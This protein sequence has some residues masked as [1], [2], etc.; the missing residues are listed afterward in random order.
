MS[1]YLHNVDSS[2]TAERTAARI[3]VTEADA[4]ALKS[5]LASG[6]AEAEGVAGRL[7]PWTGS[8]SQ[9]ASATPVIDSARSG[10]ARF[11][12]GVLVLSSSG[13]VQAA[14][15]ADTDLRLLDRP[16]PEGAIGSL[17]A[18][19]VSADGLQHTTDLLFLVPL[20]GGTGAVL[21]GRL[22][23]SGATG[24]GGLGGLIGTLSVPRG[25]TLAVL[26]VAGEE[27]GGP[28]GTV[29]GLGR[30]PQYSTP[31]QR[32]SAGLSGLAQVA[33]EGGT[34]L[35]ASY[36]PAGWGWTVAITQ[37]WTTW[38]AA[39]G[40]AWHAGAPRLAVILAALAIVVLI[41]G[42]YLVRTEDGVEEA[43]RSFLTIVGHELRTPLTTIR[44][45][46]Q[47]LT[48]AGGR[49]PAAQRNELID[50]IG[51]QSQVLEHLVERLLAG[52]RLEAGVAPALAQDP[53]DLNRRL[54][55]AVER[56]GGLS[57]LHE[58]TLTADPDLRVLGDPDAV[59]Q[60]LGH[61]LE[62]A[63]KYSPAGGPIEVTARA[64][65]KRVEVVVSDE[66]VGLPASW[67]RER[68]IFE[69]LSQSEKPEARVHDEGGVGM[70]LFISSQL[71]ARMGG[72]IRAVPHRPNGAEFHIFL[73]SVGTG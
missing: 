64:R 2:S 47:L 29:V 69:V 55:R 8:A 20:S 37:P 38:S 67:G 61:V 39:S 18:V 57:P 53:V 35:A 1:H 48:S 51:Q 44:G 11:D 52:A 43:K 17:G 22:Q 27:V 56:A 36:S 33:G 54:T 4:A 16:P 58:L 42:L 13:Q 45:F 14:D 49:L 34:P 32:A 66:G 59:D 26:D 21:E 9:Q 60:V 72:S 12:H 50:S 25:S 62:N 28:G 73:T 23:L 15:S 40:R 30:E 3:S 65:G 68:R 71:L 5:W 63:I 31:V 10:A 6:L 41:L 24:L 19:R 46:S 7:E 70:G